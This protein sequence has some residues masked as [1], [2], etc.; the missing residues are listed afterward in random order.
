MDFAAR[1][2][3]YCQLYFVKH[4]IPFNWYVHLRAHSSLLICF[5][6]HYTFISY[7]IRHTLCF[8]LLFS[9]S[10]AAVAVVTVEANNLQLQQPATPESL[11]LRI[12]KTQQAIMATLASPAIRPDP[13]KP[14]LPTLKMPLTPGYS[15]PS[16]IP[17]SPQSANLFL[18]VEP[19]MKTPITPPSAYT[20]FLKALSPAV[21]TPCTAT[22]A[23][24]S[25]SFTFSDRSGHLTPVSQPLSAHLSFTYR[26]DDLKR[27]EIT[28]AKSAPLVPPT[29][30]VR[31]SL[32]R[33]SS[34]SSKTAKLRKLRIPQSPYSACSES[35]GSSAPSSASTPGSVSSPKSATPR[36]AL[37]RS[38]FS[39]TNWVIEGKT[40]YFHDP[41]LSGRPRSMSVKQ[42]VTRT[43]TYTRTPLEPAP[44][45]KRRKIEP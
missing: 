44:R 14:S 26:K 2:I 21:S 17:R 32:A 24:S 43:V 8:S 1:S 5:F 25:F 7:N 10:A 22:S 39:P 4:K 20:D 19:D 13:V 3:L 36:S 30:F 29:P 28:S 35:I 41:P 33:S 31:P 23:H 38:P 16:A 15:L 18:K 9:C 6:P 12:S 42:V 40:K 45:G 37:P 27:P 34:T 11:L